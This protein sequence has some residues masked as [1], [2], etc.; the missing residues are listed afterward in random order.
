[1]LILLAPLVILVATA[2]RLSAARREQRLAA[3][4]LVGST[5]RQTRLIAGVEAAVAATTGT[6]LGFGL[7]LLIRPYAARIDVDGM[8]FFP[9][10]LRLALSMA[11]L[12]AVA[13]PAL[14]VAAALISLR[15]V[16]ISPLGV[17]RSAA[18]ARPTWRRLIV[19][20]LG[21]AVFGG[22]LP[23][24]SNAQG[25]AAVA[26]IVA[27]LALIVAGIAIAGPLLTMG[28]GRLL[29]ALA[30][31]PAVLLAGR[32]LA[33]NPSAAFRAISGL[34]LA[35][36]AV[37]MISEFSVLAQASNVGG[38]ATLPAGSVTSLILGPQAPPMSPGPAATMI[39][40]LNQV[41]GVRQVIGLRVTSGLAAR[42]GAEAKGG[43]PFASAILVAR[44]SDLLAARIA[45][46]ADSR[47]EVGVPAQF[48]DKGLSYSI[49]GSVLARPVTGLVLRRL[50]LAAVVVTTTGRLS[51][52]ERVRTILD[53]CAGVG[54]QSLPMT[55]ADITA[56]NRRVA[57]ELNRLGIAALVVTMVIAGL[58]LAVAVGGGLIE[59]KRPFALLRLTGVPRR[60]LRR[61]VLAE[62]AVPLLTI[63]VTSAGLGLAVAA[64]VVLVLHKHWQPPSPAYW[65]ALA[66]GLVVAIGIATGA[67]T[68][69]LSWLTS[70]EAA[71]FE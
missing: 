6:A 35:V 36:F 23:T 59:R 1:M 52:L 15:R 34:I 49:S 41:A 61:V 58:S 66:G 51:T 39:G 33:D 53:V 30:R 16:R 42:G 54:V 48:L 10:D 11:I 3:M 14:G 67:A 27:S 7:Y 25:E 29:V 71:R 9:A 5:P 64:D 24:L 70:P 38:Q 37:T 4:W 31:R 65:P 8:P 43:G 12:I 63:A 57:A 46:C 69:L 19:L 2:A 26:G 68:P 45:R 28:I 62:T 22:T 47:T 56:A 20:G 32:R 40:R 21:L 55:T 18:P 13:V 50:P 60:E 17:V 44:C